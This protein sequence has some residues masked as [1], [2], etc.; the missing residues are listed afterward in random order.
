MGA[1]APIQTLKRLL[2]SPI[3]VKWALGRPSS[4]KNEHDSI[5]KKCLDIVKLYCTMESSYK[6]NFGLYRRKQKNSEELET[7]QKQTPTLD[8][9]KHH[10]RRS[11]NPDL[12]PYDLEIERTFRARRRKLAEH[13]EQEV[14]V[15][16]NQIMVMADNYENTPVRNLALSRARERKSYVVFPELPAGVKVEI[17]MIRMIRNTAQLCGLS[18]E[19]SN[20]HIDNLLKIYDTLRQE[21]VSKDAL[22][23]RLFSFSLLGDALD[24]FESLSEDSITMWG[25]S[26]TVYEAW[27]RFRKMLR[28][29]PNHD[30]PRH[31]Q[32]HTFYHGLTDGG[33]DKLDHLNGDSFLSGTTAECHN[34]LNNLVANHYEKKSERAT[35][36][37]AVGVIEVDQVTTLNAKIDFLMQS[38]KNFGVNQ[39]QH[40]PITCEECGKGHPF[41]QC[42]HSVESI[43]FVSNARKP[44]NN[45]Y[46]NTYNPGWRQHPNFSW[47]NNQGQGSAP[48]FQQDGQQQ[49]QQPIQEKKPSLEET[50]IQFMAS[51]AANFKTMETQIGQLANAINS[52]LQGSLPSNTEPN[53]R[54]DGKA[55]CQAVTLHNGRELQEVVKEP[56]KQKGKEVISEENEKKVETPL[57]KL[58]SKMPYVKFMKD[59]LS[60]KRC[61]GDYETVALTKE[62]S[63]IIQNKLS[64]KL[65]D[66]GNFTIPCTI[67]THFLG[68]ALCDLGASIN[69]MPYSIYR[70]L[71]LG[72]AKPTSI[73][74]QLT[75]R[76]L[77][78]PKGVIED[79]LVKVDKFIFPADFVVLDM[80]V[81]SEVPIILGRHFLATGRTLIDVQ[82]GE[83]TMRAIKFPNESDEYFAVSL[84]DNLAGNESIAEQSLDPLERALLDLLDEE[85]E[86]DR[87][88]VKTLDALKYFK[89][90]GVESLERTAPSKVLK[91]SIEDPPTLELKPLPSHLCYAYLGESDTLPV[92]ISSALSD[93]QIE[94]LLRV[95]RNHKGTIGWTIADIKGI[96]PSF[97]MHKILLEDDQKPSVESQ[98][99]MNTIMKEV[100]KKEI[101]KWLDAGIIYPISDSSWVS[102]V[103][104]VPKKGGIT[105]VPNM[106]NELIPTRTVT[107]WRVCMDYRKLNK[108]TRKDHFPLPFIDQ[109]L[110]R[111][112]RKEFY[113][114]LDGYSGY[115][116]I[117]ITPEDQEKITFTCPYGTFT[118]RRMPFGLCNAPATLQRCMMAIFT[119]MIENFLEVFMDNFSVY[120][121]SFDECLN[122]LSSVLK[123]FS[124]RGIEVDKAKLETIEKLP[125]PTSVKGVHSFSGYAGFYRRFIKDFSKISKSLCN[126]LEK[127]IP[128]KF[129]D[130][131]LDAFNDLK[132]RLISAPIITVAD[133]SFPFEL[134]CDASDFAIGAVLGQR[135]DKIFRSIY[136]ASKTLNDAQLNYTITEKEL[137]AVV[138]TFDKF[139]SYLV[140]TKVIVY[141]DHTA[142]RYLI[143]TKDAKPRLIR[144]VLLLQEFDLK[145]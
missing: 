20:R 50:L 78:Y 23:L 115:N 86:E 8:S 96:S 130:A 59:I 52:R 99:K 4:W 135:K 128:F 82:K 26:E 123:R 131:C 25:V 56:P 122:N 108:A 87:E 136:Y 73:T 141:T 2:P 54:Q 43:Q 67:G 42:P 117:A 139:R 114:F 10:M 79:I 55:Q 63:A 143:E 71:G 11:Q 145:I 29:C 38:M 64:P 103:Q 41:D 13:V 19:N 5:F 22:R 70:T 32:V 140:G 138:F 142:I 91:L 111:L 101:I 21:G 18:H 9:W 132:R 81:D 49:V 85:N 53:P 61:L 16:E 95:L 48:R 76:S 31:I 77:T 58:L 17:P 126:L 89:S 36:P 75:D 84:F 124:N 72:E 93:L 34:L 134:M 107:G 129:D 112:A 60:K 144:W 33:K 120:G 109:M 97:C 40:T 116:Q 12:A 37:K 6:I 28:N 69:L 74:L 125:P 45:P 1:G 113:C 90:R 83:L 35:P 24:W 127:D 66:P 62:Y 106:H 98:K 44:Q 102:P 7:D 92:I 39:V 94:K 80:E 15:E 30:I 68:R 65:K 46:S 100:V 118:F 104:C 47:N 137:L 110:D 105:V 133:W 121:N 88:V 119:D 27:S 51:T 14:K 57:E 3:Y